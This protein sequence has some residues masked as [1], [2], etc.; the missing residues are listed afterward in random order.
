MT[1]LYK[2]LKENG[3]TFYAF[4]GASESI[5]A[6]YQSD[7]YKMYFSKYVL[8]NLPKQKTVEKPKYFDFDNVF[9]K[10]QNAQPSDGYS[11]QL[12]ESLRNYV[13]NQE[14]VIRESRLN[15]REYYYNTGELK[16]TSEKIFWKWCKKLNIIDFEPAI[17][18]DE[19]FQNLSE[20]KSNNENDDEYFPE[21]LWKEREIIDW[22]IKSVEESGQQGFSNKLEIEF[23]SDTNLKENDIINI[24]NVSDTT[25][26]NSIQAD[27]ETKKGIN[28]EV[29]SVISS[30]NNKNQSVVVDINSTIQ[31]TL[32]STGQV[33]IVYNRLVR[34][35]G[36]IT[37]VSNVQESNRSYTEIYAQIPDHTG[38]TPD[39]LFRTMS[40]E[41]YKPNMSFPIL[42]DQ[43]QPEIMGAE[44][45]NS[46]IVNKPQRYPGSY[47]GQFDTDDFTYKIETGDKLRK[48]GDYYGIKGDI[49]N[50]ETDGKTVD[51]LGID[52]DKD[53]Y[54]K[55]NIPNRNAT[56][57]DQFNG[58]EIDNKPPKDFEYNSI[59]WY[60]T[61]EDNNGN[62]AT[63]LYGI[64]FLNNPKNNNNEDEKNIRF[65]SIKKLVANGNQDGTSYAYNLSLNYNIINENPNDAYN[66]EAI[67]SMFSMELFNQAMSRLSSVNDSF[68]NILSEQ[69]FVKEE[70]D[71]LKGLIYTQTDLN[72]INQKIDNL[73]KLLRLYS[74]K[75]LQSS[76]SI[77]V[78]DIPG[79][80]PALSLSSI[81]T[82]YKKV[83]NIK[84]KELY[85]SQGIIK[86]NVSIPKNKTFLIN[87][88]NDDDA[89]MLSD[90][91]DNLSISLNKDL[92]LNQSVDFNITANTDSSD[93][94]KLDIFM[95]SD[96]KESLII[97]DIN[98]PVFYNITTQ[99]VNS[100]YLWNDMNFNIN[101]DK[102]ITLIQKDKLK[103][104]LDENINIINNSIKKGDVFVLN[105]LF[106]GTETVYDFSDQYFVDEVNNDY[107]VLDISNNKEFVTTYENNTDFIV[108]SSNS[109]ELANKPY[110]S[111]NKGMTINLTRISDS[112][113]LEERYKIIKK[114]L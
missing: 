40:D 113:I 110:L 92:S 9:R 6:T 114:M 67:N 16:T 82:N 14:T 62:S 59:L 17:P 46:P 55:M 100:S 81:D 78:E 111:L 38:E 41:N 64:S 21:Y 66:P 32:E 79:N 99:I 45:F 29:L 7:S 52:F 107:I 28:V 57:F 4:P 77:E 53:H 33:R 87:I 49:N 18:D 83:E 74:T 109:S 68:T 44:S 80:P 93:N 43:Y 96:S 20:F 39:V 48:S 10:S 61:V 75:Q 19:Y 56:N 97:G 65:P 89:D 91:N 37:G 85:D 103:I 95:I 22:S 50:I 51:G 12:V 69:T 25:I 30:N 90:K 3:T 24:Y 8:L 71:R 102:N 60:Y 31:K 13:A 15:N 1:P 86:Y 23:T 58:M 106:I 36:E 101:F 84:T 104:Y 72:T 112:D 98:L 70:V 54:V 108:H 94:K 5:S 11:E 105:N 35:I 26:I 73:E 27:I 63:N 2:S 76:D 34:Y 42:P 88:V 47:I